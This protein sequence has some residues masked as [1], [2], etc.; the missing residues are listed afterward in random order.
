MRNV[1]LTDDCNTATLSN[2]RLKNRFRNVLPYDANR[3]RLSDDADT[4]YINASHVRVD[5]GSA[6]VES[7]ICDYIVGQGPLP[8][9]TDDFWNMVWQTEV[10]VIVMLTLDMEA[11][12]VKC[13]RYWPDSVDIP[14]EAC[15][16]QL[17]LSLLYQNSLDNFDI[18][19]IL[20]ENTE[21]GES[22][23]LYHLN[24]TTWPDHG[25]PTS[26]VPLLQCM[27]LSHLYRTTGPIVVHCS[28]GIGR[29]GTFIAIDVALAHIE[30]GL[31]FDLFEIV[32]ELRR[33]R[34]GMI[35]TRDQYSFCYTACVEALLETPS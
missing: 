19:N 20:I 25:T 28:A 15:K 23:C 27:R 21:T 7:A 10:T 3:V 30:R 29:S 24:Y 9:T 18:R 2:N 4:D 8:E 14:I 31:K 33:Q 11:M 26:A 32:Q 34:Q 22:R 13:H 17:R 12:K 35:Q 16:G 5:V 1:P 6:D